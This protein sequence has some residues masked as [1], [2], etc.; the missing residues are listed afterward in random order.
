MA[1]GVPT[2]KPGEPTRL[3][4]VAEMDGVHFTGVAASGIEKRA[5]AQWKTVATLCKS[6]DVVLSWKGNQYNQSFLFRQ[7]PL[8]DFVAREW[9]APLRPDAVLVPRSVVQAFFAKSFGRLPGV[10]S[11]LR[12]AGANR[13][14]L[15]GTPGPK[16]G[17][18]AMLK[19]I[20]KSPRFR[21]MAEAAGVDLASTDCLTPLAI[22]IKLWSLLQD[23]LEAEATRLDCHFLP[24]PSDALD[25]DGS[26]LEA[27]WAGDVTHA[28][29][30]YGRLV[31][32][33]I[34]DHLAAADREEAAP[35]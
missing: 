7:T 26:L 5:Y 8:F 13:I 2:L 14:I 10:I 34:A 9:D 22:R 35:A 16:A 12:E 25:K 6:K 32:Q 27:Y 31:R 28:N 15:L 1:L 4:E 11:G 18:E 24:V 19:V 21:T 23:M 29:A 20:Q 33:Q 30:S 3:V 17:D